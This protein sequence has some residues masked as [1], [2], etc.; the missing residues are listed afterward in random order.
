VPR[1]FVRRFRAA[2]GYHPID[3]VLVLR[4]A[5]A[6][7]KLATEVAKIDDIA[8]EEGYEYTTSFRRLS[9]RKAG[10][11]PAVYRK[12]FAGIGVANNV[13]RSWIDMHRVQR[14]SQPDRRSLNLPRYQTVRAASNNSPVK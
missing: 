2:M 1:T 10:L 9:K 4:V 14:A 13:S 8:F 7:N 3:Y 11:T 12:K 6:N 5:V